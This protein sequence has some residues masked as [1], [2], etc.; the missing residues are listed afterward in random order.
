VTRPAAPRRL[1]ECV[2]NYSEGR[3]AGV[4]DAI[5]APFRSKTGVHLL[6]SRADPDHNRLVVSLVGEPAPLQDALLASA[7]VA[8][9]H[10]DMRTHRGAHPRIG[11]VDVIPFVPLRGMDMDECVAI[12]RGFAQR[13]ARELSIPVYL[14][15]AAARRPERRNLETVR[16]GQFE[17]LQGEIGKPDRAPDFGAPRL[18]PTAGATAI[19]ARPFLIAFNVNLDSRDMDAARAIA[20]TIRASSGGMPCVKAVGVDLHERGLVQVSINITDAEVSPVHAVFERVRSEASQ[21]GITVAGTELYGMAPAAALLAASVHY[22]GI[23]DFDAGQ[24]IDLRLL[25]LA[26]DG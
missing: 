15:E 12:A 16:K 13:Y 18:H 19:G 25:D 9:E 26:E 23:A 17:A 1:V 8:V 5:V 22:L 21:R 4:I 10:I 3:R 7:R 6:D 2:P 14:Y 24:V 11:A 20:R